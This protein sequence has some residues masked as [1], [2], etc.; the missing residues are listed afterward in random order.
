MTAFVRTCSVV[1]LCAAW[2]C[3]T[4]RA[5]P[6][7]IPT[8]RSRW[9]CRSRRAGRPTA[10]RAS[11]RTGSA[12]VLG[13]SIVIENRGGGAG[14]SNGAKVVAAADPDGYTILLTPG[15]SLTIGPGR[16]CQHR[17]RSGQGVHAGRPAHRVA[18]DHVG[19]SG[20]AGEDAGRARGL[21][22]G[23]SGQAHL[24]LAGLRHRSAP[25]RR[26]VQARNRRQHRA[27]ALSRHG[28]GARRH[29]G[30]RNP[31]HRRLQHHEPAAHPGRQAAPAGD[32]R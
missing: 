23:Q 2:R 30:R 25:A 9:W 20:R 13:Q 19:S 1:A 4:R 29:S 3:R 12:P 21:R 22:Q 24:G 18:A 17:L 27:R 28:A 5:T 11:S 31:D 14:G 8:V 26:N 16:A 32:R 6:R 15:G 7:T 10:W